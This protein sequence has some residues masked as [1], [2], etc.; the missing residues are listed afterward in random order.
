MKKRLA[1][2]C[3]FLFAFLLVLVLATVLSSAAD[4]EKPVVFIKD[5]GTGDGSS[6][7][8]PLS[9]QGAKYFGDVKSSSTHA[10]KSVLFEAALGMAHSGGTIVICGDVKIGESNSTGSSTTVMDFIFP[11]HYDAKITLTSVYN[12]VDYRKTANARLIIQ[13]PG[14]IRMRGDTEL[15]GLTICTM[16]NGSKDGSG[17]H[18]YAYGYNM[19][20]G[21]DVICKALDKNGKEIANPAADLYPSLTQGHR[22]INIETNKQ[23]RLTVM[24][25]TFHT[26]IGGDFGI[27]NEK[28][29]KFIGDVDVVIGG[30][31]VILG[32]VYGTGLEETCVTSGNI[33][34]TIEGG[35]VN[36]SIVA[37]GEGGLGGANYSSVIRI[38]GGKIGSAHIS[39][40]PDSLNKPERFG[41]K[42]TVIDLSGLSDEEAKAIAETC[43]NFD[44][45]VLPV[46]ALTN[47]V[48]AGISDPVRS[49]YTAGEKF[50]AA[51][52]VLSV[53]TPDGKN[54]DTQYS[55]SDAGFVITPEVLTED[56]KE[57]SIRYGSF[58]LGKVA[59]NVAP[60]PRLTIEG[61]QIRVD[62]ERQ[63]L[64]F[65]AKVE[66]PKEGMEYLSY[67][68]GIVPTDFLSEISKDMPGAAIVDRTGSKS[69]EDGKSFIFFAAH[70]GIP[71]EEYDEEYSAF[72]YL[73]YKWNGKEYT[74]Y[75]EP[76]S[77]SV[78]GIAKTILE[79][80]SESK[81][82]C[83][84]LETKVMNATASA[85]DQRLVTARI[86]LM[87]EHMEDM[88]AI[89]WRATQS[90][91]FKNDSSF[92]SQLQYAKN[93][94]Y[95][96]IPYI[97]GSNDKA[98][99]RQWL[100][101]TPDGGKYEGEYGWN[102]MLGNQC[103]TS[104][105]RAL[106]RV[107]NAHK[108]TGSF[109]SVWTLP[110]EGDNSDYVAV[111]GIYY[112]GYAWTTDQV[113]AAQGG[114]RVER[115]QIIYQAYTEARYG[116]F[117]ISSWPSSSNGEPLGHIRIV[118]SVS[119]AY[120]PNGNLNPS[121]SYF[122]TTE[123]HSTIN[124]TTNSTWEINKKYSFSDL[125]NTDTASAKYLPL[126]VSSF[127][128]GY[129]ATPHLAID[130]CN[131]PENVGEGLSG[132]IRSNYNIT[133]VKLNVT[134]ESGKTVFGI[135]EYPFQLNRFDLQAYDTTNAVAGLPEGRYHYELTVDYEC[136]SE[137]PLSFDFVK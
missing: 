40:K 29:G 42:K 125:Y 77:R 99:L 109:A 8:S 26:V 70:G 129:F 136:R 27:K 13:T 79:K 56:T 110:R 81:N 117:L 120:M 5:G 122:L 133:M 97:A 50:D 16:A 39:G 87:Q 127:E 18:I 12:G 103:S 46:S 14:H 65:A 126:R 34:I 80:G 130:R 83:H 11:Q 55:V 63:S 1:R 15:T 66:Q 135:A 73:T 95:T 23:S 86:D 21:K 84:Y 119:V 72:A 51:G 37:V 100:D 2:L 60:A 47:A 76:V 88:A 71:V 94:L 113:C 96:G 74:I 19:T 33:S 7:E 104:I 98:S 116:D 35:T 134:D 25:G 118:N 49:D 6:A 67:G 75:S 68:V 131:T 53:S 61:A 78:R 89:R 132:V 85:F 4:A 106:Q 62:S 112:P 69:N 121:R 24:S 32:D 44:S 91:D 108:T 59:V 92:T 58:H 43:E 22:Y 115:A 52:L 54:Y 38:S 105:V 36:G 17:R 101:T 64:R 48:I 9:L 30:D 114:N 45:V 90:A 82:V 20:I 128:T 93:K 124:Q 111:G 137:T 102:T 31:A 57:V 123:Q 28:Y 3:G 107:S 10:T 41:P